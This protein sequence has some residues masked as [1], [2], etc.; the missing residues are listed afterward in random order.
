M[1][2]NKLMRLQS[3]LV[4]MLTMFSM[5][6]MAGS[7]KDYYSKV[8]VKAVGDGKVYVSYKTEAQSPEYKTEASAESG[9]DNQSFGLIT[10]E[11][12]PTAVKKLD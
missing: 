8:T 7:N 10:I 5:S 9:K 2:Q 6:A 3:L 11:Y 4:V 12:L 1:K